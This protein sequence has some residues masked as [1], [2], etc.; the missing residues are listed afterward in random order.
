MTGGWYVPTPKAQ[1]LRM[2]DLAEAGSNDLLVDLGSGDGR[3][4]IE[5]AKRGI[6]A[7]GI[8]LNP[9]LFLWSQIQVRRLGLKKAQFKLGNFW[10]ED[11]SKATVVIMF[12]PIFTKKLEEKLRRELKRGSKIVIYKGGSNIFVHIV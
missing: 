1:V 8:E 7:L 2:L 6:P 5:A 9:F 10:T 11:L 4:V 12:L 3:F